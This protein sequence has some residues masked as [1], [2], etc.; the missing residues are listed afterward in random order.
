MLELG[1][2]ACT[3]AD[4][5]AM[6]AWVDSLLG[7]IGTFTYSPPGEG[8]SV[9]GVTLNGIAHAYSNVINVSGLSSPPNLIGQLISIQ[10]RLYRINAYDSTSLSITPSIRADIASGTAV[11]FTSPTG[12]F[13][14]AGENPPG[15]SRDV[16]ARYPDGITAVEAF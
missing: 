4:A 12:T 16:D 8:V 5:N 10:N 14:L 7:G 9:T 1:F 2:A 3:K 13:R 11:N 15:I 6:M